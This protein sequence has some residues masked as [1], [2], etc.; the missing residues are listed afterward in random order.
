MLQERAYFGTLCSIGSSQVAVPQS[1]L[2]GFGDR[3]F[4]IAALGLWNALP[5]SITEFKT[6]H[7]LK[8]MI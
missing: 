6:I 7:A 2:K 1:R 8:K 3:A 5:G 4:N